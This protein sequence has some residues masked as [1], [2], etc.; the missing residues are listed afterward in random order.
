ME[1]I[2]TLFHFINCYFSQDS[3]LLFISIFSL[4][5]SNFRF[6]YFTDIFCTSMKD[7][8]EKRKNAF[9]H[10]KLCTAIQNDEDSKNK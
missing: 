2:C 3:K 10:T 8:E 5:I 4:F 7:N 1:R 6:T 9:E